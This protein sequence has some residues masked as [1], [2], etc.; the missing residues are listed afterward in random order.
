LKRS[1]RETGTEWHKKATFVSR[2]WFNRW[3]ISRINKHS[4]LYYVAVRSLVYKAQKNVCQFFLLDNILRYKISDISSLLQIFHLLIPS[5]TW[6]HRWNT[7]FITYL[8]RRAMSDHHRN[9][10]LPEQVAYCTSLTSLE[11][12]LLLKVLTFI[13]LN[14][15]T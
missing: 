9:R 14:Y 2:L 11:H 8:R 3:S 5:Y 1:C 13:F 12:W 7:Q 6:Y 10:Q 4:E 15:V